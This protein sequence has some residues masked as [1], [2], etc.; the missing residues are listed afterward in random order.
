MITEKDLK[1]IDTIAYLVENLKPALKAQL[2][3]EGWSG[4]YGDLESNDYCTTRIKSDLKLIRR[5]ALNISQNL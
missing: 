4:G 5:L 3:L 2:R 1:T